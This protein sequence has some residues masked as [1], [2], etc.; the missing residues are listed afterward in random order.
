MSKKDMILQ[1]VR[2]AVKRGQVAHHQ[3]YKTRRPI[4]LATLL[5]LRA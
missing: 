1:K 2:N 3:D 5:E 4:H